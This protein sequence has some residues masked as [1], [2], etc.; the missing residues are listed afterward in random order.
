MFK[1]QDTGQ[2]YFSQGH[3][4]QIMHAFGQGASKK[5]ACFHKPPF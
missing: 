4:R 2:A 5:A 3:L 1:I